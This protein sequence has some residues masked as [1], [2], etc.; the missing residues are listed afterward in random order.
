MI[1]KTDE[2]LIQKGMIEILKS[3]INQLE[4]VLEEGGN[5]NVSPQVA[6]DE[7]LQ[8]REVAKSFLVDTTIYDDYLFN[9][10]KELKKRYGIEIK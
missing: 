7:Y 8:A 4:S 9:R 3:K 5:R 6:G 2:D 10:S 1:Y